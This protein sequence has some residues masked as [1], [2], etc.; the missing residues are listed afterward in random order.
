MA[1]PNNKWTQPAN[2]PAPMFFGKK[3]RNLVKQVNTELSE[4]VIGQPIAYYPISIEESNFNTIYGE[5]IEKVS[6]PPVRVYAYVIVD[7]EQTNERF[8][9][10]YQTKLTVNF[11]NKR[12][13][14]DQNLYVRV[15]DFVQYGDFFYEIVKTFNDTRYYFG[16]VEHKFQI[17]AECIRVREDS[18]KVMPAITRQ[19]SP[20][21]V[22]ADGSALPAPRTAPYPPVNASYVLVGANS[23]VTNSRVLTAGTGITITDGGRLGPVTIAS[24][25]ANAVG[26]VGSLQF[27]TG[28]GV[29]S[30]SANL[31]FLS[32]SNVVAMVGG[33]SA[34]V[35]VSAFYGD[36]SNLSGVGGTPGGATTQLQYNSGGSFAG[37]SNLTFNGTTLTGSYTGSL[38]Q[39]TTM[40]ASFM[41][42]APIS[43]TMAGLG[44]YL[45]L[46]S[47]NNVILATGDG[48]TT[49]PA[50]ATT[51]VQFNDGGSFGASANL[52]F[53]G[54]TLTG[55]YTG[56]LAQF[57]TLSA[58][59]M[60][61]APLSG[62]LAG[63]GSYLGL[64]ATNNLILTSA[65]TTPTNPGGATTQIQYNNADA[66]DGSSNLTFNGI[67][68]TGSYT[69][70]L[71]QLTTL[72][73]SF[74]NFAPISGT[75]AGLGSYLALDSSN[76]V[77]LATGDGSTTSPA[78]ANTQLQFNNAGSFGASANL[79]YN[80]ST[81]L[82]ALSGTMAISASNNTVVPFRIDNAQSAAKG[83]IL[84][85]TGS[86]GSDGAE[87]QSVGIGTDDPQYALDVRG[88]IS[89]GSMGGAYIMVHNDPDT[90]IRFG[91][92]GSD[93]IRLTAGNINF[94][95]IDENGR[96]WVVFNSA[97]A[98]VDFQVRTQAN[99][100]SLYVEGSTDRVG[101]GT[102]V[103][104]H[105][106][107][108]AGNTHL[109]GGLV[110]KHT[111]VAANYTASAS[112]YV[113][114]VSTTPVSI[115]LNASSFARGQV[116]LVKDESGTAAVAST[117]TLAPPGGQTIDGATTATLES[118]YGAVFVYTNGSN[119]FI[120]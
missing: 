100:A 89:I 116:L 99:T 104:T 76:N 110:H 103:P 95:E 9:Y 46:D 23:K 79:T 61:L 29:F 17:S 49:S 47:N 28:A 113:L 50:G 2:P 35:N 106:L 67:T 114:G 105:T 119:W 52:T 98:D 43:G 87:V 3:E 26:P 101:I 62:T 5:S 21:T 22:A 38:G 51:Q 107:T 111:T 78:G 36:G 4:R 74:V 90:Y 58:S 63:T 71:A 60:N 94:L 33:L 48:S 55:S 37:S 115:E 117:I 44:S 70:S 82:V 120:Y 81:D 57:T 45:A 25:A 97:S 7:N 108:T 18:F 77:I 8:G 27:Q 64:S 102:S 118:P 66:F 19:P 75:M 69:G 16:Q 72:S 96:D 83:P 1:D 40:S 85:T 54:T 93:S 88:H 65:A 92:A 30:G 6:L 31:T 84:F 42:V 24:T 13:T 109:S 32:A 73:A 80:S 86:R 59:F 11:S 112:D 41:N 56:S 12:I 15:G 34:S 91:A 68:L 39:F 53:S 20:T 14:D 10:E